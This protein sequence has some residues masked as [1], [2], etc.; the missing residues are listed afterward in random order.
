MSASSLPRKRQRLSDDEHANDSAVSGDD[1]FADESGSDD[2]ASA[3]DEN[4]DDDIQNLKPQKSRQ[5]KKRKIRATAPSTFGSALQSLL[6]TDAPSALPLSLKPSV[7]R[8]RND[9]KLES[10][11]KKVLQV[12]KKEKEDKG[13]IRDIYG[14]WGA[15]SECALR[16]VAQRGVVKLF[17]VIQQAQADATNV[18]QEKKAA[19][20]SGKPS[21]PAPAADKSKKSKG[22]NRDNI[23]GR[24][25]EAAVEKDDFFDMIRSGGLV[26]K[27]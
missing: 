20:G 19:R 1:E 16:K 3:S 10:K 8:K 11:A 5:T 6:G 12:E 26:S 9:E 14:G 4:S 18:Q 24:G 15:E 22:K 2:F 13:R 7:A 17:N 27:A 21:L 25:K 23:I